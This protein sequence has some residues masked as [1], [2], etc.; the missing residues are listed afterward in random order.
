MSTWITFKHRE[1][2]RMC[3]QCEKFVAEQLP[4][5]SGAQS[6]A[7]IITYTYTGGKIATLEETKEM[8]QEVEVMEERVCEPDAVQR[9]GYLQYMSGV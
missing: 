4:T 5:V 6:L 9:F 7:D 3:L 8:W 1:R 2:V